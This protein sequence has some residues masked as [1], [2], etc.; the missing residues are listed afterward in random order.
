MIFTIIGIII[1]LIGILKFKRGFYL[2]LFYKLVLVTNITVIALP[3]VPLLTLDV[4]MTMIFFYLYYRNRNQIGFEV[5]PF[6]LKKPFRFVVFSYFLSTVFAY[7][8][9]ISAFSQFIGQAVCEFAFAWLMWK[10]IDKDDIIYLIKGFTFMFFLACTYGFYEKVSQ[11]NPIVLYEMSLMSDS[12]IA[13]DFLVE[14]DSYRGYRV[15]SFF[16]H[17]IGAG[18]NWGLFAVFAFSMMWVYRIRLPLKNKI[19]ILLTSLLCIPC[20]FFANNRGAI[21]FFFIALLSVVNLKDAKFY[22][23]ITMA[24]AL[25]LLLEPL[26]SEYTNNILSLFD[27]KAQE[28]VGGS[29]AE[30]RFEQL[31]AAIELM[32]LSPIVGL[33]YKFMNV[34]HTSLVAA[35]LGLESMWFRIL[36]QFGLLGVVANL[37]LAYYSLIKVP[38]LYKSMPLFFISL[39]YWI[40]ASLTSVPGMKMYFYYLILIVYI[41]MSDVYRYNKFQHVNSRNPFAKV[42]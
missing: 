7:V 30:M 12:D 25:L 31:A 28:Q 27:P 8:G 4:F 2:F 35:L 21:V 9:F 24:F 32:K 19:G 3:G 36:T 42:L 33:G 14:D 6:P 11:N 13:I 16:E 26:F 34:M 38:K 37:Y 23:R 40:T 10:V 18:I 39:A 22:F 15:Q 17:A 5:K 29:N 41:K 1:I 20:L